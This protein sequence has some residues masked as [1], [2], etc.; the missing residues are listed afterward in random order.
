MSRTHPI[1]LKLLPRA[2]GRRQR[3]RGH[4]AVA[5]WIPVV[6]TCY[7][8]T[9][10]H[11]ACHG[12]DR[13]SVERTLQ[14]VPEIGCLRG[15]FYIEYAPGCLKVS[16]SAED[17]K[18][19]WQ[20]RSVQTGC[21][22]G[23]NSCC[24]Q[25]S[26]LKRLRAP[27]IAA[28]PMSGTDAASVRAAA[29]ERALSQLAQEGASGSSAAL[30]AT[31]DPSDVVGA[32]AALQNYRSF[33]AKQTSVKQAAVA[34][35]QA[36]GTA[37]SVSSVRLAEVRRQRAAT[38]GRVPS[39]TT[40]KALETIRLRRPSLDL[41]TFTP[42]TR[43]GGG[44]PANDTRV[45]ISRLPSSLSSPSLAAPRAALNTLRQ[46]S[47]ALTF[48]AGATST[49]D[50]Q[51]QAKARAR[52]MVQDEL[53]K[54]HDEEQSGVSGRDYA[55]EVAHFRRHASLRHATHTAE[56]VQALATEAHAGGRAA[57]TQQPRRRMSVPTVLPSASTAARRWSSLSG[58]AAAAA[59]FRSVAANPT[60]EV[61]TTAAA[62][63]AAG[64][65][66]GPV[67][68]AAPPRVDTLAA[69]ADVVGSSIEEL[70][71]LTPAELV[72]VLQEAE[73]DGVKMGALGR[74]RISVE[75]DAAR[76][77]DGISE[78]EPEPQL[79]YKAVGAGLIREGWEITSK[80]T[81]SK[82]T[83]GERILALETRAIESTVRIRFT[84]GWV[85]VTAQS[86]LPMLERL[87]KGASDDATP[88]KDTEREQRGQ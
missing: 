83:I 51:A 40:V 66:D 76:P 4:R 79:W 39:A 84:A 52:T 77:A 63:G 29:R 9:P 43:F 20:H 2:T 6:L 48:V 85:S 59:A 78:P 22:D 23:N 49:G 17:Q 19:A 81:G 87:E 60:T 50:L 41:K 31:T 68:A 18:L 36:Q 73:A 16:S 27:E 7:L 69:L 56:S 71:S 88:E 5:S 82:L 37:S 30:A 64:I 13:R 57:P 38:L 53:Q 62:A 32:A 75:A 12:I 1:S 46:S 54:R 80:L 34:K 11:R 86:G 42:S 24:T 35:D 21:D 15:I 61:A 28:N 10:C 67:A 44:E 3:C 47:S 26:R 25:T 72:E 55:E 74:K 58:A 14:Q 70:L 65:A 45:P 8:A 33:A